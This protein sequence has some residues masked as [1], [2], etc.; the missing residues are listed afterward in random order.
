MWD[1]WLCEPNGTRITLLEYTSGFACTR[2]RNGVGVAVITLSP[3]YDDL[4]GVDYLL[5][6]WRYPESGAPKLFNVYMVR[7]WLFSDGDGNLTTVLWGYDGNYLLSGRIIASA[8][9]SA[10]A[11]MTAELDDMIKAIVI[12]TLGADAGAGR[13][14]SSVAGGFSVA[15]DLSAAPSATKAFA[16]QNVLEALQDISEASRAAG[17]AL[18]F[19][20][21]PSFSGEQIAWKFS[22]YTTRRG[23]DHGA[24]SDDPVYFGLQW[25]NLSGGYYGVDHSEEVNYVY[26]LG[27]GNEGQRIGIDG[28]TDASDTTRSGKSIW[29]L[30]E[31][32]ANASIGGGGKTASAVQSE[33]N[34]LMERSRPRW[35]A[36]GR[37]LD[38][39]QARYDVH[40]T[41]GDT[42]V[43][44]V[45]RRQVN[46]DINVVG[47]SVGENGQEDT[48][49]R[50]EVEGA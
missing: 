2:V 45:R 6:F 3:D 24:D 5:E 14:L 49:I 29:N 23:A 18:Y 12:D 21:E 11:L 44:E 41:F 40:W 25:G 28:S 48:D 17:T 15:A 13:D 26:G 50:V 42:V 10:Q 34:A 1:I 32:Y 39:R 20:V 38:T 19:D 22:T 8:A 36:G 43:I 30:R 16:W 46:A 31:D 9:E 37:L 7:K 27:V 33:A 4:F 35:T 47:F